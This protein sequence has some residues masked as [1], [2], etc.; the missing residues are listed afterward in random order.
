MTQLLKSDT[1]RRLRGDLINRGFILAT[2][3]GDYER[4]I[5]PIER[6][7][8]RCVWR[9]THHEDDAD[10]AL[11]E[12]LTRVWQQLPR[13]RAHPNPS[14]L[15]LRICSH[16]ACDIVRRASRRSRN[17]SLSDTAEVAAP[18]SDAA[19]L[20]VNRE[21]R[22]ELTAAIARLPEQQSAAIAMRFLLSCSYEQIA[23]ALEC[24]EPTVRVHVAR[25][26]GRLRE[27]LAHLHSTSVTEDRT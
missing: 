20:I 9:I 1:V 18:A 2:P 12:A 14:A 5:R 23:Q 10:D 3:P 27:I 4:L 22:D 25:G 11:Q 17:V 15:I 19:G 13:V 8:M 24:S 21:R 6:Q 7:M 16:A 26:L